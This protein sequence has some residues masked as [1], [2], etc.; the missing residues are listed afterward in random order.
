MA[1]TQYIGARYVPIIF[2]NPDDNSN[3]WKSGVAYEPLTI[4][5]YAGGSY[6][7]KSA[8]PATAANPVDAPE[9]WVSMGLYSGQTAINTNSITQIRHAL[10]AATEAGY[11]CTS[12]REEGDLVWI[13]GALYECTAAVEIDDQYVEG[14]NITPVSDALH[15]LISSI[16]D[17]ITNLATTQDDVTDLQGEVTNMQGDVTDLQGLS[18]FKT[19]KVI[20]VSDSYGLVPD[21][22]TSW[23]GKLKE[24]LD[25]P[26]DNFHRSQENGSGFVGLNI[27]TFMVQFQNIAGSM[28]AAEKAAITDII[29]GGGINDATAMKNGTSIADMQTAIYTTLTYIRTTFPNANIYVSMFGW[30]LNSDWHDYIR[31]VRNLYQQGLRRITRAAYIDNVNWLHRQALLDS[32]EYHPNGTGSYCIAQ[33][34]ASKLLGGDAYC[35]LAVSAGTGF[36]EPIVNVNSTTVSNVTLSE[37]RQYYDNGFATMSWKNITFKPVNALT[38]G[39]SVEIGSFSDG[40]MSGGN[41]LKGYFA[42]CCWGG[43]GQ[44][45]ILMIMNNKLLFCNT[46]G[47][48][49]AAGQSVGIVFGSMTGPIML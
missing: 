2:Q 41:G 5:S 36:I 20:C 11:V 32:T 18:T 35:D 34:I 33:S 12:P 28:T 13:A 37:L 26:N 45:G 31:S 23:I 7:S 6:T 3:D 9:Y 21:L 44:Q 17:V 10:A 19:R 16:R 39:A 14:I 4:V 25:I 15:M 42:P 40:I 43:A 49:I 47:T 30:R 1:V 38:D 24:F 27:N 29:I 8:V 46:S 48:T 22:A